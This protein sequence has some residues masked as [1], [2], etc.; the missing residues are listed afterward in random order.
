MKMYLAVNYQPLKEL[1]F[2]AGWKFTCV[3]HA[4]DLSKLMRF[5]FVCDIVHGAWG[6]MHICMAVYHAFTA[7]ADSSQP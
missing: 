4:S 6:V 3:G 5:D 7:H 1:A 2:V